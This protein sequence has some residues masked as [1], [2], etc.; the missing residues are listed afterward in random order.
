M[1]GFGDRAMVFVQQDYT[2]HAPNR[3]IGCQE[4]YVELRDRLSIH[5]AF[6]R[7]P[8]SNLTSAFGQADLL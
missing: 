3:R 2:D 6:D 8:N 1:L 5:R 4:C 7:L